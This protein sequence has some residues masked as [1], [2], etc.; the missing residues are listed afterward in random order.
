[1]SEM[2]QTELEQAIARSI[3][4]E[5][6]NEPPVFRA[7]PYLAVERVR[8]ELAETCLALAPGKSS[9]LCLMIA[10]GCLLEI[11]ERL[12]CKAWIGLGWL[13]DIALEKGNFVW[14]MDSEELCKMASSGVVSSGEFHAWVVLDSGEIIDPVVY[15]TLAEI[16]ARRFSRGAGRCNFLMPNGRPYKVTPKL[17]I[18]QYHYQ[19]VV[20]SFRNVG[21]ESVRRRLQTQPQYAIC[22][23]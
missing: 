20:D 15:P 12:D 5:L 4:H 9:G 10:Q 13:S 3:T 22:L 14:K 11:I 23:G 18:F 1:M 19:A 2:A 8:S 7:S 16:N 21:Q 17:P 6:I